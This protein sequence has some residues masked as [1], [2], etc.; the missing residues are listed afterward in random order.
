MF[1]GDDVGALRAFLRERI[2]PDGAGQAAD[3]FLRARIRPSKQLLQHVAAQI[4]GHDAFTLL[5]EQRVALEVVL[6]AV[7]ESR[8]ANRKTVVIVTGGPGTGKSVIATAVLGQL[9]SRGYNVSHATGSKSFTTT[10]ARA[11]GA[12]PPTSSATSTS[13][14]GRTERSRRPHRG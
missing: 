7:N 13:W 1:S 3:N 10:L 8:R 12:A 6:H 5:D 2:S 11:S 9:A 4:K 14:G